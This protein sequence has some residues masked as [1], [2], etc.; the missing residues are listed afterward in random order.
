M[1]DLIVEKRGHVAWVTLNRPQVRNALSRDLNL[2]MAEVLTELDQDADVRAFVLTGAGDKVFCAGA[3]LKERKGI[4]AGESSSYINAIAAAITMWGD[5]R[6]PTICAMNGSAYG[7][8]L[9]LALACDFR[10]LVEGSELAL[11]EV[12]LGIMPGAGGTQRL[13]RLIGEAR[14]KEMIMLGRKLGAARALE[15]GLV[16]QVVPRDQLGAAI[17]ALLAELDGCAPM[18]VSQAKAAIEGGYGKPMQEALDLERHCYDV[19][20]FSFDRDEGLA[21]FAEGRPPRYE[22]R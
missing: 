16:T 20:L 7:G 22:G 19:T 5:L 2:H 12:R 15:I 17:D 18:S 3:D 14:A 8:G 10:I 4:P 1:S 6:K 11:T 13:P 9:E 21:A